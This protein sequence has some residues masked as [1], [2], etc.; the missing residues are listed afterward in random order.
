LIAF[1]QDPRVSRLLESRPIR[2]NVQLSGA[3]NDWAF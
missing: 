1:K 2:C 3:A